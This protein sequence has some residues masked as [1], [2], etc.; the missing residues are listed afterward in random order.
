[1]PRVQARFAVA[2]MIAVLGLP[3]DARVDIPISVQQSAPQLRLLGSGKMTWFGL[4]L[5]D[6]ALWTPAQEFDFANVFALAIR[7]TRGFKGERIA[8]L[9]A[10]EIERLG[11]ADRPQLQR[12]KQ[13]M[14]RMFP[15]VRP[16]DR[17]TGVYQPGRGAEFFHQDRSIGGISDPQFAYAFF[18]I[19]LDARTREPDLREQL[20]GSR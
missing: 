15:D 14:V 19:W 17:L 7:Y 18:S 20:I 1:M 16:G 10:M 6:V 5:Y 3:A 13:Q 9:S 12:W 4:H 8:Q 11:V 2:L